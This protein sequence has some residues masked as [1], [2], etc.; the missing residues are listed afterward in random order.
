MTA[1][2][3]GLQH[4]AREPMFG[5]YYPPEA[6]ETPLSLDIIAARLPEGAQLQAGSNTAA[7]QQLLVCALSDLRSGSAASDCWWGILLA[8]IH[9][10]GDPQIMNAL[11]VWT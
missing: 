1:Y 2:A 11:T 10:K 8:C 4:C 7:S 3:F 9:A 6:Q 5:K